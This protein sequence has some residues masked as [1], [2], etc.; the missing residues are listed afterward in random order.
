MFSEYPVQAFLREF[1][2]HVI[3]R[4]MWTEDTHMNQVMLVN[5]CKDL[6]FYYGKLQ[7]Y[8]KQEISMHS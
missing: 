2:S 4:P 1:M 5:R 8:T 7:I 6:T 3:H